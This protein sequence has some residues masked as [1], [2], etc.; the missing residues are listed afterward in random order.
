TETVRAV[1]SGLA[2][3]VK[4]ALIG[5][6]SL[7]RDLSASGGAEQLVGDRN[8]VSTARAIRS[9]IA[10]KA[11]VVGRDEKEEGERAHLNLGHTIGHALEAQGGF[12]ALTHGEAVALGLVAALRIGVALRVTSRDLADDA[13]RVL[14]RLGL[15]VDL[16]AQ[17]LDAA[18]ELVA[19]D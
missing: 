4:T 12:E 19:Y 9:S 18:L 3:V 16:G 5:D 1:R 17:P 2:E 15:P 6:A 7:Y 10:V 11:A 14:E 13:V 8:P